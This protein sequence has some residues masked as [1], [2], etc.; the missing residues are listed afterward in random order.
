MIQALTSAA[1][2]E[3][4]AIVRVIAAALAIS[5]ALAFLQSVLRGVIWA[6][7][8]VVAAMFAYAC[9]ALLTFVNFLGAR[10]AEAI[11]GLAEEGQYTDTQPRPW[12]GWL[13]IGPAVYC[14]LMLVFMASDLTVAILIFEAMGLTLGG[15]TPSAI[16]FIPLENAMGVVFVA[17][18]VFWG[19]VLFDLRKVTPFKY[20][21]SSLN[22]KQRARLVL[23]VLVCLTLTVVNGLIMG[24]WSQAQLKGGLSEPWQTVLP[25]IIRGNLVALLICATAV[26]G[27]PFGSAVT[28]LWV[29]CL[30]VVRAV[31]FV[32]LVALRF[33]LALVRA[34]IHVPLTILA[35]L[36]FIGHKVWNWLT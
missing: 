36:A 19:I 9:R 32:V 1:D 30:L 5:L 4:L 28:A 35:L 22:D 15:I 25:W 29:V 8:N 18:A 33:I 34:L 3:P 17:L 7:F 12:V 2:L 6:V 23:V 14:V 26:A 10:S 27:K 11:G 16:S 20:I 31:T 13:I 21:W 24:V